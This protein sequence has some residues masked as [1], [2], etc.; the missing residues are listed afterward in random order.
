MHLL[1]QKPLHLIVWFPVES[2]CPDHDSQQHLECLDIF[3]HICTLIWVQNHPDFQ[4]FRVYMDMERLE[5]GHW[6][7]WW[8]K[9]TPFSS[10]YQVWTSTHLFP[11]RPSLWQRRWLMA[12]PQRTCL[13]KDA[14]R[15]SV[16]EHKIM[17][18]HMLSLKIIKK[19][20]IKQ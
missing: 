6:H 2:T 19:C 14:E 13:P 18:W 17:F 20:Q 7:A 1:D 10:R 11:L 3:L 16:T 15:R 9:K 12:H 5:G 8:A 4:Y